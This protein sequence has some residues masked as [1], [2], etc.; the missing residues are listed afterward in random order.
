MKLR[1]YYLKKLLKY[2]NLKIDKLYEAEVVV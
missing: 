1:K 2:N